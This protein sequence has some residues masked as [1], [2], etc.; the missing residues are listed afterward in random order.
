MPCERFSGEPEWLL[1]SKQSSG[2]V[3][4]ETNWWKER[5]QNVTLF[6]VYKPVVILVILF[7]C[8]QWLDKKER[9]LHRF[10]FYLIPKCISIHQDLPLLGELQSKLFGQPANMLTPA[11]RS[12]RFPPIVLNYILNAGLLLQFVQ[13]QPKWLHLLILVRW[14][15]WWC[16]CCCCWLLILR[17]P[18]YFN[19]IY[20]D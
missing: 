2:A 7:C 18:G 9:K 19:S 17:F 5:W 13:K 6:T 14:C 20:G 16:L 11:H 3:E 12:H 10:S 8:R 4:T 1:R 15:C